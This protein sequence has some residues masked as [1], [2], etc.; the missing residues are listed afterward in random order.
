MR[1]SYLLPAWS[2]VELL[3]AR[4]GRLAAFALLL[5]L[6]LAGL[7][8]ARAQGKAAVRGTVA[9]GPGPVV[10]FATVT[11]HRAADSVVVKTEFSDEKGSF[12][13]EGAPGGRYVVSA[14]QVGLRRAWSAP[15]ALAPAGIALPALV[16]EVSQATA[17][18]EVTVTARKPLFEHQA[19]RTV[20]NVADS[21]LSAGATALDVLN[22]APGVTTE[23]GVALRG[24]QGV[25]LVVDGK[26]VPLSGA[27][28][29]DYLRALPAEQLQSIELIT[30]PPAQ[31]D[32]QGGAGVIAINLKKDQRLGTNGSANVSYGRGEYGK[33]T[34][35]LALNHRR[36]N[37]NFYGTYTYANRNDFVRQ[38]F[39]RQY[40]AAAGL[41]AVNSTVTGKRVLNLHSHSAR[42][43]ADVNLSKRTLA[44]VSLTGLFSETTTN[45]D[46]RTQFTD[47]L[48]GPAGRYQSL[49]AQG[50][51][52]PNGS[53][54][55]N[56]RHV[57]ADSAA[58]ASLTADADYARYSTTR[59]LDLYTNYEEPA[60]PTSLLT[61]DQRNDLSIGALKLDYSRP[62]PY[63][64]RLEM[65]L[66]STRV[67]SGNVALFFNN[68]TYQPNI[69]N[70][71]DYYEN[72]NAA[73]AAVR[74]G[75]ASTRFQAGLRAEQATIRTTLAGE[76]MR[77]QQYLQWFPTASVQRTLNARH[78]L[79][80]T[81]G[82]RV[83]RP[84][85]GQLNPLRAYVDAVSYRSGNPYLVAQTSYNVDLTHTYRQK[86]IAALT[87]A[88]THLPI[89]TTVQ[90]APDG[91]RQVVNRDV[92]LST[93]Q[94]LALT[95]TAPLEPAK[96]WTLYANGVF[97][98]SRFQGELAGTVLDRQQPACQLSANNT[99]SL[100]HGWTAE[101]NGTFQSGE[102]WGFEQGRPRE[103]VL[104][105]F[106]R[107]FWAKQ[108]TLRLNVADVFYT[109]PGRFTSV[110]TGFSES[111]LQR[112]DT[113]V[114]TAAF[115]YRFGSSKV[116]AARK[117]MAGAEDELRRAASQ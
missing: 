50:I 3:G 32:A 104:V 24:R 89:I 95:L 110:Y 12:R 29:A 6:W 84:N 82:R 37:T 102:I 36:K 11:L 18:K 88:H 96:W 73:Y 90:P 55:L 7:V 97:Y 76:E 117:R 56:L 46:T 113:R 59:S 54:N 48:G 74:G 78:A 112:Q 26:R 114:A 83:D 1:I 17:L 80:L 40:G 38:E 27:E 8:P 92:N 115:T 14:A 61:G 98:Y 63:R 75:S 81:A 10:E 35:G 16:L 99:F 25:L 9:T 13:L 51:N 19:D 2:R 4:P 108:A 107:S 30:N 58:A 101:L 116:A 43:G 106:Q 31:Y 20:V 57:F 69:S 52:R 70:N 109:A 72:V 33:F 68:G 21:P 62:L 93:Q 85:Y 103:Q 67:V 65:G 86:F 28:L 79:A 105:G 15:F 39:Y 42:L 94:Y 71:F 64:S 66:K 45:N 91:G 34:T 47:E 100:P 53:A 60:L 22:R 87:Y 41:P 44:G 77:E 49:A 5:L 23:T 111:F